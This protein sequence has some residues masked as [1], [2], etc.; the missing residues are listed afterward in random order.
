MLVGYIDILASITAIYP[1]NTMIVVQSENSLF[2]S[3]KFDPHKLPKI[4]KSSYWKTLDLSNLD[5]QQRDIDVHHLSRLQ[6]LLMT[7]V[8]VQNFVM[9]KDS[10]NDRPYSQIYLKA[11]SFF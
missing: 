8:L 9:T 10:C 6:N 11:I 2:I 1:F 3:E 7:G 5:L 4:A